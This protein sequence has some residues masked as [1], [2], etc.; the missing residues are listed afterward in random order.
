MLEETNLQFSL[1]NEE[2][3]SISLKVLPR[4]T[5]PEFMIYESKPITNTFLFRIIYRRPSGNEVSRKFCF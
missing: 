2:I 1:D 4:K 3:R 5:H